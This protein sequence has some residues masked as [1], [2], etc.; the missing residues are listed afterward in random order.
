MK[1]FAAGF[2]LVETVVGMGL[3]GFVAVAFLSGTAGASRAAQISDQRVAAESLA[4]SQMEYVKSQ[5]YKSQAQ[6]GNRDYDLYPFPT[7]YSGQLVVAALDP[8]TLSALPPDQD[9]G[10]QS[11]TITISRGGR[12]MFAVEGYKVD[13]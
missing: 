9:L 2:T 4:R 11:L 7:G 1:R 6:P 13:R 8:A 10:L 5:N 3:L 12:A